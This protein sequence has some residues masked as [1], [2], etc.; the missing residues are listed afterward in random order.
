MLNEGVLDTLMSVTSKGAC[1]EDSATCDLR[2]SLQLGLRAC[3]ASSETHLFSL[4]RFPRQVSWK[5]H[6]VGHL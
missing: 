4:P 3:C 5:P 2:F 6:Q 1:L